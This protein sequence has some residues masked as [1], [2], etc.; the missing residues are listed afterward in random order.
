MEA[1]RIKNGISAKRY[2]LSNGTET[3]GSSLSIPSMTLTGSTFSV[4]SQDSN[5]QGIALKPDGTKFFIIGNS[6]NAVY[7]YVMSTAFT[8]STA[9]YNSVSFSFSAQTTNIR[10]CAV[11][12]NGFN[13][14]V[15]SATGTAVYQY[16]LS[17]AWDLSTASYS[18]NS[19]TFSEDTGPVGLSISS[20]GGYLY[21]GGSTNDSIYQYSLSTN[22]DV[23][24][25]SYDS[26][27]YSVGA[28]DPDG[29]FI[30][31]DGSTVVY[32][33]STDNLTSLSLSTP[34]DIS[35]ST[36]T[37]SYTAGSDFDTLRGLAVGEP[38]NKVYVVSNGDDLVTEYTASAATAALDLSTGT[39]FSFTPSGATTV[40]FTNP[41]ASGIAI[42]FTVEIDGDGSAI[43]WPD[44]V[45]WPGGTAPTATASKELYTFVTT[46]GG[47]EYYGKRA[48]GDIA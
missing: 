41:P 28:G 39:T 7:E 15:L 34:Y 11:S 46:D 9:S 10:D 3:A 40:S 31:S 19:F 38:V 29:V 22:Y 27:S 16:T 2:L 4:A 42:G 36:P 18:G 23:S 45:K 47:T 12:A 44:S 14:Y 35:T 5:P 26:K 30:S 13:L 21:M 25:A 37:G 1:F 43:T 33:Q 8:L 32:G 17:T 48:A 6:T 20:S 24:T